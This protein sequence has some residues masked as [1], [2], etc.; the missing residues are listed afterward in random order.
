MLNF[1]V[2]EP[3]APPG[4]VTKGAGS[5]F[6]AMPYTNSETPGKFAVDRNSLIGNSAPGNFPSQACSHLPRG[7]TLVTIS[8]VHM[9]PV[10]LPT[11]LSATIEK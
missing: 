6:L 8:S 9:R 1:I 11:V 2:E 5:G 10:W 7:R 4:H 3:P